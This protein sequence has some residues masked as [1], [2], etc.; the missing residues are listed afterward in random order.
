[1]ITPGFFGLY[2][3]H[4]GLAAA[5]NAL[6][7]I[8]HNISNANTPGY[9]RQRV[10]LM[11]FNAYAEP[12]MSLIPGGQIGQGP[13]L[14]QITRSRDQFLDAQFRLSNGSL[15]LNETM[16][17]ALKQLE[18]IMSEPSTSGINDAL[19]SFFNA[20]QELSIHPQS[21]PVRSTFIQQALDMIDVFQ[22]QGLQL[23][24]LRQ[25]LVGSPLSPSSFQTSQLSLTVADINQ[26]LSSIA[27]INKS[28]VSIKASGA[29]P[30]DLM[31][32]RDKLMDDLSKLVDINVTYYDNGQVDLTIA[33]QTMIRGVDQLDSLQAVE[34]T[35]AAPTP[36]DVPAL[37]STVNGSV[38]LNDGAGAEITGGQIKGIID[39]G[40]SDPTLSSVRTVMGRLDTL[41]GTIVDQLN[42]LQVGQVAP[43]LPAGRDQDGNLA[44]E[45]LFVNDATLNPG[46]GLDMFH[47]KVNPNILAD[48]R[49]IAAA[50][51][52]ST[53]AGGFAGAGDGRNALAMAQLRNQTFTALGT[54]IVDYFNSVTAKLGIDSQSYQNGSSNQRNLTLSVDQQRQSISGVNIDEETI[55]LLRYQRML[56][57]TSKTVSIMD[58]V[59]QAI[60]GMAG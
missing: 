20:A 46:Q 55:D 40:G 2:N 12:G 14:E 35:G 44:T 42:I 31:D 59:A 19:Q 51:D 9:S 23:S 1:M 8:Q 49:L 22:Q 50:I 15:G 38:V 41:I 3:A 5:Q 57:A 26:K 60:I 48:P 11:A 6:S 56:E 29:E 54:G 37:V 36:D 32:Q 25:N 13:T 53:V 10:D 30:N 34:N 45:A 21:G 17:D 52:D 28:I 58:Q 27:A 24:D 4:R 33:G 16:R 47:W 43:P 18:G 39:M 7:T